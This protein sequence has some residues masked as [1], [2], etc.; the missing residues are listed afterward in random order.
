MDGNI[1]V[2]CA[3]VKTSDGKP[4]VVPSKVVADMVEKKAAKIGQKLGGTVMQAKPKAAA[5]K[6]KPTSQAR[7]KGKSTGLLAGLI[8]AVGVIVII[9]GIIICYFRLVS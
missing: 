1:V 9:V 6:D 3:V 2:E 5:I 4:V 8:V 7:T